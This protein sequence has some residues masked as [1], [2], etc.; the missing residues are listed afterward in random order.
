MTSGWALA[1]PEL[2][3]GL[4]L[5]APWAVVRWRRA[6]R[7]VVSWAPLQHG[8][9]SGP[10]ARSRRLPSLGVELVL[11]AVL[12]VGAA[13]PHR[14]SEVELIEDPGI[15]LLLVLDV[16]LSMLATDIPPNRLDVLRRTADTFVGR[17]GEARMGILIFAGDVF[18]QSPVTSSRAAVEHLLESVTV[19]T[20]NHGKSGGTAIGD[21]LLVA[22]DVLRRV[23]IPGRDQA[24]VLI[25]DGESNVGSEPDLAA[26]W[27]RDE[28]VRLHIVGVGGREPVEVY[29]Q[30]ERVGGDAPYLAVLDD[31]AL[32]AISEAADG[33]WYRATD[34]GTLAE[35]FAELNRLESAPLENE[36][37]VLR[38][39]AT[40][41]WAIAAAAL[42]AV[43]LF[44]GAAG[45][46]RPL[47]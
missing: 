33:R 11:V 42:F 12:L 17:V 2:L 34:A 32:A 13:G 20:L 24:V 45:G 40:A 36:T 5:L 25:T 37:V 10:G 22:G 8:P 4:A 26:R 1:Q 15:D 30:G 38:R 39:P 35:I 18:V 43:H 7:S 44:F 28:G 16:S 3:W 23:R 21:A 47:R 14:R 19:E 31:A 46:R 41:P 27:L 29:Y 6:S 9:G